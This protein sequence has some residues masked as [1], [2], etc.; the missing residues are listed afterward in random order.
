M[1][2]G[3]TGQQTKDNIGTRDTTKDLV[4]LRNKEIIYIE[5]GATIVQQRLIGSA[6]ILGHPDNAIL[7]TD[8]LG[9]GTIGSFTTSSVVNPLDTWHE[10][11]RDN[12]FYDS[13]NSTNVSWDTTNFRIEFSSGGEVRTI[14]IFDNEEE[15]SGVKV[16]IT[17]SGLKVESQIDVTALPGGGQTINLT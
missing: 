7:G 11:F 2:L 14:N 5:E 9:A 1:G 4:L 16:T 10:H 13:T 8:M 15:I 12:F 17:K 6:F 3:E